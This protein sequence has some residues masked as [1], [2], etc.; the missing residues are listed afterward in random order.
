MKNIA[1]KR[2]N[3]RFNLEVPL[4]LKIADGSANKENIKLKTKDISSSGALVLSDLPLDE[5]ATL[6]IDI[7]IPLDILKDIKGNSAKVSIKGQV[8]RISEHGIA[9]SFNSACEFKY[10]FAEKKYTD[11]PSDLTQ[12][13]IE[14]LDQIGKGASN[15]IIAEVL[16]ISPHTVKTHLHNIFKK[17]NVSRRLQ[18][19]LW[20]AK[21]LQ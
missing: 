3:E 11:D 16:F 2:Q 21:N 14:I 15:K 1:D 17:I 18:A 10:M 6:E 4:N 12:R 5:G 19:A 9:L 7:D 20:T 8:I 13:E